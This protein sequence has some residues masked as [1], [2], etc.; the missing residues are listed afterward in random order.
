MQPSLSPPRTYA[1]YLIDYPDGS[2]ADN[3]EPYPLKIL[4]LPCGL[5][6]AL[7]LV[8]FGFQIFYILSLVV[9]YSRAAYHE[10]VSVDSVWRACHQRTHIVLRQ[11][12]EL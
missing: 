8:T 3:A 12:C 5:R 1:V 2:Y 6:D 9:S 11:D 4:L 10:A 7:A